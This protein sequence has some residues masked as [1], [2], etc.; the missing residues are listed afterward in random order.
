MVK[1]RWNDPEARAAHERAR[2]AFEELVSSMAEGRLPAPHPDWAAQ[3]RQRDIELWER[4]EAGRVAAKRK[5][6]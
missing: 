2:E 6:S 4:V 5:R 3:L 1:V